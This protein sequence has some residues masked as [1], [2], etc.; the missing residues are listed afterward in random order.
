VSQGG[1]AKILAG[2][3]AG[4]A[5]LAVL[6][7]LLIALRVHWRGAF[8]RKASVFFRSVYPIVLGLGGWALSVFVV[9]TTMPGTPLDDELVAALSVG[10]PIGLGIYLAWAGPGRSG[11]VG[12]VA[13]VAG[14]LVGAW[15]GF[16]ATTDLVALFTAIAGSIAG[17]NLALILLDM[18]RASA[19]RS[20]APAARP[21]AVSA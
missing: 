14:G 21:T 6:S 10:L 15:L 12:L 19:A 7:L 20:E 11:S 4:L 1:I 17:A 3:L 5:A 8:G 9:A 16:H 13:G 2:S 18:S